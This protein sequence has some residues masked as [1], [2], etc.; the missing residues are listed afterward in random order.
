MASIDI[1]TSFHSL[2]DQDEVN[3]K[4][5]KQLN[6]HLGK[7]IKNLTKITTLVEDLTISREQLEKRLRFA[8]TEAP[9]KITRSSKGS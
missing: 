8:T 3:Y 4:V 1:D 7:D 9:D 6:S 2:V 5:V